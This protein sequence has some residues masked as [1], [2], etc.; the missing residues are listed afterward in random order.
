[1]SKASTTPRR[2]GLTGLGMYVP[3]KVL[4]NFDLAKMVETTDEWITTRTGIKERHIA[5][6]GVATSDLA[7]EA[8]QE[9]LAQAAL[10]PKDLDLI[11]TATTTPDMLFPSTSCIIQ[12]RLGATSAVCFDLSAACSGSVFAMVTAQQYLLTGRLRWLDRR[13]RFYRRVVEGRC[14][15]AFRRGPPDPNRTICRSM[16]GAA[17]RKKA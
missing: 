12:D 10:K 8:A 1:M 7:Y 15:I 16:Y 6:P 3:P 2:I 4:T 11:I 13:P 9:A 14:R 5:D 17:S